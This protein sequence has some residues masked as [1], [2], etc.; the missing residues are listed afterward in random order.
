M[1]DEAPERS[2]SAGRRLA[3][4][5]ITALAALVA[6]TVAGIFVK[7][8]TGSCLS[9]GWDSAIA[10][11]DESTAG[12]AGSAMGVCAADGLFSLPGL[13]IVVVSV[14]AVWML[15]R[16]TGRRDPFA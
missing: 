4:I 1:S 15:W 3:G 7:Q 12:R 8:P 16:L 11:G 13:G 5:G 9:A 2:M 10:D 6:S 14:V